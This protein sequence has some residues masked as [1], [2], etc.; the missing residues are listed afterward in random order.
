MHRV[1]NSAFMNMLKKEENQK[2]HAKPQI[3]SQTTEEKVAEE[4]KA[5]VEKDYY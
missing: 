1:Y 5:V 4:V 2:Q 3:E